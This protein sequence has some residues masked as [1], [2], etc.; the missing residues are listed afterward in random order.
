M[1]KAI[2]FDCFGVLTTEGLEVFYAKYFKDS[3]EKLKQAKELVGRLNLG[4]LSHDDFIKQIAKLGEVGHDVVRDYVEDNRANEPLF[5]YIRE[6][7][8]PKY[9]IGMLSNAGADWL[10]ELF[11]PGDIEL[12]DDILLS[13]QTGVPKPRPEAFQMAAERLGA[14]LEESVM[15]DDIPHYADAARET[16]MKV[17]LYEDFFQMK[18]ELEKILAGSNN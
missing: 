16:G 10:N 18:N 1:I 6:E 15:V 4:Q 9:K 8:K 12:F 13:F 2:I 11:K 17:I 3:P 5:E 7:L 14:K